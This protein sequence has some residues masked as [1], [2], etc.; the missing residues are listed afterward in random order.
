MKKNL[1]NSCIIYIH[2]FFLAVG[3]STLSPKIGLIPILDFLLIIYFLLNFKSIAITF[4]EIRDIVFVLGIFVFIQLVSTVINSYLI[5]N[6]TPDNTVSLLQYIS[7]LMILIVYYDFLRNYPYQFHKLIIIFILGV[8]TLICVDIYVA[9]QIANWNFVENYGRYIFAEKYS[10]D[11]YCITSLFC[12]SLINVNTLGSYVGI[13]SFLF[14]GLLLNP[15]KNKNYSFNT[16]LF[17]LLLIFLFISIG[18]GQKTAYVS[19]ILLLIASL[20]YFFYSYII[21]YFLLGRVL[22]ISF[23]ILL[24]L[25]IFY[26]TVIYFLETL[27]FRT[28]SENRL[29]SFSTRFDFALYAVN[30]ITNP[31]SIL[32]GNG[33]D[34]YFF[35]TGINDPHNINAQFLLETGIVGFILYLYLI[36]KIILNAYRHGTFFAYTFIIM[37]MTISNANGLAFQSHTA[38]ISFVFIF[39]LGAKSKFNLK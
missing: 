12:Y 14:F 7:Y 32:I 35:E 8:L 4:R 30:L 28:L 26:D 6:T 38:W 21:K 1:F 16:I 31:F 24:I 11:E 13:I 19:Y 10:K 20:I 27:Y 9:S 39:Y 3:T 5:I 25:I 23:L 33:K 18:L 37:Y 36:F 2:I 22:I 17:L 15:T 34:S 29:S